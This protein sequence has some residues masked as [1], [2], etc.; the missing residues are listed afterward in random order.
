MLPKRI[1]DPLRAVQ[2]FEVITPAGRV[3]QFPRPSLLQRLVM[4]LH[5]HA[6]TAAISATVL[7]LIYVAGLAAQALDG[8]LFAAC[9]R[10]ITESTG[11]S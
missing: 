4:F 1:R 2:K 7:V 8:S 3:H 10:Q 6:D 5:A 9:D 11:S